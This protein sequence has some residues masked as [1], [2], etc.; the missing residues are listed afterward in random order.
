MSMHLYFLKNPLTGEDGRSCF[1]NWWA[2][3]LL[4]TSPGPRICLVVIGP[5]TIRME[6]CPIAQLARP[7]PNGPS[8]T[9]APL[10]WYKPATTKGSFLLFLQAPNLHGLSFRNRTW[11]P[12]T[13]SWWSTSVTGAPPHP[14]AQQERS[15]CA[16]RLCPLVVTGT[17]P[18][19][20]KLAK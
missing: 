19:D 8:C 3:C 11:W 14:Q 18:H 1:D 5:Y 6:D 12:E 20:C 17:P 13:N 4:E 16:V 2:Q 10:S 7:T 15:P 9:A